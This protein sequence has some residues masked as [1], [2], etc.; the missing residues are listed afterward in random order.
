MT[1]YSLGAAGM[2]QAAHMG[3]HAVPM[4]F[5]EAMARVYD[6]VTLGGAV[7]MRPTVTRAGKVMVETPHAVEAQGLE[8]MRNPRLRVMAMAALR[9][10]V[11]ACDYSYE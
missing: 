3:T 4:T 10:G 6:S 7:A 8:T 5:H 1:W 2:R 9:A 11:G